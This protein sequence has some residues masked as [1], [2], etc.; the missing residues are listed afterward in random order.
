MGDIFDVDCAEALALA[1]FMGQALVGAVFLCL[2]DLLS[3]LRKI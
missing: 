1:M 3:L 2:H